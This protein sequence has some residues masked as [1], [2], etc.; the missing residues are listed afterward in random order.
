MHRLG[1][2]VP[3]AGRTQQIA[4]PIG[5]VG[6]QRQTAAFVSG[7]HR[8]AIAAFLALDRHF[9][10]PHEPQQPAGEHE[11]IAGPQQADE[12]FLDLA[13][14]RTEGT[15][16]ADQ[17]DLD[18]RRLHDRADIHAMPQRDALGTHMHQPQTVAKQFSPLV[19]RFQRVAA[20]F[21]KAQHVVEYVSRVRRA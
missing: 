13:E 11:S 16:L 10:Q 7:N 5:E 9:P 18:H 2:R 8:F 12:I 6:G 14:Y 15:A 1:K 20:V 17:P 19:V 3:V 21:D 4:H